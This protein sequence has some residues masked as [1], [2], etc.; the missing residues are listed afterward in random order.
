MVNN[1]GNDAPTQQ[2]SDCEIS[3][4]SNTMA[5]LIEQLRIT[6]IKF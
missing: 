6:A 1:I 3:F 4:L 5:L 2:L